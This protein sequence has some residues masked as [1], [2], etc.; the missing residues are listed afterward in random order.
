MCQKQET[1]TYSAHR[2]LLVSH[3]YQTNNNKNKWN[4]SNTWFQEKYYLSLPKLGV[5][6]SNS[7]GAFCI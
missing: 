2:D 6:T 4:A 7:I 5:F 3:K 1:L